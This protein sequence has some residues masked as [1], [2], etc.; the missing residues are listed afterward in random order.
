MNWEQQTIFDWDDF[1]GNSKA[2]RF[3]KSRYLETENIYFV[4]E[5]E[6]TL[7]L[8]PLQG[9]NSDAGGGVRTGTRSSSDFENLSDDIEV[10][11]AKLSNG[12]LTIT[13]ERIIPEEKKP[14]K[15]KIVK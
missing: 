1:F 2:V 5:D 11:E 13:L 12:L 4:T 9:E 15:I 3:I 8:G 7:T 10:K 14:K 6:E